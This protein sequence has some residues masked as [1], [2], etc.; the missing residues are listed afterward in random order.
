MCGIAGIFDRQGRSGVS[1]RLIKAMT[2]RLSH[3]GPDGDG[4]FIA[5]PVALGH[6]RLSIIDLAGGAQPMASPDANHVVTFNGEIYNFQ[7]IKKELLAAGAK[8]NTQS[9]TEV[10]LAAYR[11]WG[12]DCVKRLRGM[13]AFALWDADRRV[14]VL[15]RDRFGKKPLHFTETS[16]GLFLFA[17]EI[18]ALLLHDG[19]SRQLRD[20]AVEDYFAL[21]YVPDPKTIFSAIHK[22]PAGHIMEVEEGQA[23]PKIFAY[24]D[25]SFDRKSQGSLED[26]KAEMLELLEDSVRLRMISDVPL[27]AFLSGGVDSSAIVALMSNISPSPVNSCSISFDEA[28][29]DESSYA[30]DVATRYQTTHFT[31]Q[32]A[33]DDFDLIDKLADVFDEPFADASALPTYRVSELARKH[34]TVALSGDGGDEMLAGYRRQRLHMGEEHVRNILPLAFRRPFFATLGRLYPK[35]DWAPQMFRAKS[36]FQS[37]ALESADA[38]FHSVSIMSDGE[39]SQ[40]FSPHFKA[41]LN[42]YQPQDVFRK[43]AEQAPTNDPLGF[44]QYLDVKTNLVGDILTKTDR[45][46]MAHGLEVRAPFLDHVF[47]EWAAG[48]PIEMKLRGAQGKYLLKKAMEGYL[49]QDILYRPKMGFVTPIS[50]WFKGPLQHRIQSTLQSEPL[51]D[52]GMFDAARLRQLGEEHIS[53]RRDHGRALWSLLM[54]E[55]CLKTQWGAKESQAA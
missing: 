39:R 37:L 21:G 33:V 29:L 43:V 51:L 10:L 6:R 54:F 22:L 34:V 17:S 25:L 31:K 2:A 18:K 23:Q 19:V 35:L 49:P 30:R 32:V 4:H 14:L 42:G 47:A 11:H 27:G 8:F 5:T 53:G 45:A 50:H 24:W 48:L 28:S 7:D 26:L 55:S 36:T 46:S 9:D 41:R 52:S 16:E 38:Y 44:I 40:L 3:R 13:F 12:V 1:E 20:D 15:A